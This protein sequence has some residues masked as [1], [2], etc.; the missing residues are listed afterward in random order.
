MRTTCLILC[1]V[2]A[3]ALTLCG[4]TP[5]PSRDSAAAAGQPETSNKAAKQNSAT[6]QDSAAK[7]EKVATPD[8]PIDFAHDIL[9]LLRARCAKCH[10]AGKHEGELS[11]D[12]REALLK[13]KSVVPGD[14]KN[15]ELIARITSDDADLRMPQK[16]TA[17]KP[18]EIAL[19][20]RWID[21]D[22]PWQEGF[23]FATKPPPRPLAVTRPKL[24]PPREGR[25]TPS[26]AWSTRISPSDKF[27]F[28]PRSTTQPLRAARAW[29]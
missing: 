14:A 11:I 26:T 22:L 10:A 20:T 7:P 16:A 1:S 28:R 17:L 2:V 13:S 15:S 3:I 18:A 24:P 19:L 25:D 12:T 29:I 23:S 9:P 21:A 6:K 5:A 8:K 4:D 27:P